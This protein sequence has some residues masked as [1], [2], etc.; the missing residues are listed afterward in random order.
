MDDL[1]TASDAAEDGELVTISAARV[2]RLISVIAIASTV[3]VEKALE[4]LQGAVQ[5]AFGI[6]EEGFGMFLSELR[7]AKAETAAAVEQLT[8][9]KL[10]IE[11]KLQTIEQQRGEIEELSAPLIDLWDGVLAL[12]LVGRVDND[13]TLRITEA[14]LHRVVA[15]RTRWVIVD[16]T[17]VS[18]VDETTATS[19]VSMTTAAELIGARCIVTGIRPGIVEAL[20]ATGASTNRLHPQRTLQEGLLHCLSALRSD[21]GAVARARG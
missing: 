3:S 10:E 2:E 1:H 8:R 12:P 16:L 4:M 17:G 11:Q 13:R 18:D 6:V 19:L 9:S 21:P 14:L 20:L 5:D 7:D 15:A